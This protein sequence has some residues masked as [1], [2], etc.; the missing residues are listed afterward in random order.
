[1]VVSGRFLSPFRP[2]FLRTGI[3]G[4]PQRRRTAETR[5]VTN[6]VGAR[7]FGAYGKRAGLA[8]DD[9]RRTSTIQ[10]ATAQEDPPSKIKIV[11]QA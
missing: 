1:M 6:S 4:H 9:E 8:A 7:L 10:Y 3:S 5:G 2:L 11:H